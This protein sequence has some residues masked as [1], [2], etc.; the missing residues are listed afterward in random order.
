MI[1]YLQN[2]LKYEYPLDFRRTSG[3]LSL[4]T[5]VGL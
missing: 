4:G 5:P 3:L 1:N 2:V